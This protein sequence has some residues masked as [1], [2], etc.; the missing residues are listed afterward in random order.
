MYGNQYS[1]THHVDSSF[2]HILTGGELLDF[3]NQFSDNEIKDFILLSFYFGYIFYHHMSTQEKIYY[4]TFG[5][6]QRD[7]DEE[8]KNEETFSN[9]LYN[10][11]IKDDLVFYHRNKTF[12]TLKDYEDLLQIYIEKSTFKENL[13]EIMYE[14]SKEF[15]NQP[16]KIVRFD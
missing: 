5:R 14:I 6:Y 11:I 3:S 7:Y 10:K 9:I 4:H 8:N 2:F 15:E 16:K 13:K 1:R 12:S